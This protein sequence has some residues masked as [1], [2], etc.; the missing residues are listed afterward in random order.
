[1]PFFTFILSIKPHIISLILSDNIDS[2]FVVA[3]DVDFA[4]DVVLVV[5]VNTKWRE[6]ERE[7]IRCLSSLR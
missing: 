5:A 4:A 1:M 2:N 3:D 7:I 6:E